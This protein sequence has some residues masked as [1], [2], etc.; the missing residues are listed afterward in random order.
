M[1][2]V[3][4]DIEEASQSGVLGT[5]GGLPGLCAEIAFVKNYE[6][7]KN[8]AGQWLRF[9]HYAAELRHVGMKHP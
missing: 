1:Y 6:I 9:S 7:P 5:L 4:V 3:L 2:K 8:E